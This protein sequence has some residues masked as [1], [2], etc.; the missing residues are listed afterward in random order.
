MCGLASGSR[1]TTFGEPPAYDVLLRSGVTFVTLAR[2]RGALEA[3]TASL[4]LAATSP[5][6][7]RVKVPSPLIRDRVPPVSAGNPMV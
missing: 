6:L 7:D 1:R 3:D 5:L 2:L 4:Q